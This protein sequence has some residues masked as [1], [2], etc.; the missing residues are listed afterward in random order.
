M[1]REGEEKP[2]KA[3]ELDRGPHPSP[4]RAPPSYLVPKRSLR[5]WGCASYGPQGE[6][7]ASSGPRCAQVLAVVKSTKGL[8]GR[9]SP[10]VS[11]PPGP[12]RRAPRWIRQKT[13]ARGHDRELGRAGAVRESGETAAVVRADEPRV[14][15]Q[16]RPGGRARGYLPGQ[17]APPPRFLELP[18]RPSCNV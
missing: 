9:A 12:I 14:G 8:P 10:P 1:T 3:P 15:V 16:S 2:G 11:L 4:H 5:P 13:P 18:G 7:A 17:L 6:A